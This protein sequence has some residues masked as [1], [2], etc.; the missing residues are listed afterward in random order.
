VI[1]GS[2]L[3]S[4]NVYP[5]REMTHVEGH[6]VPAGLD[7]ADFVGEYLSTRDVVDANPDVTRSRQGK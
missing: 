5:G 7:E 1:L 4:I 3:H 6:A 2:S